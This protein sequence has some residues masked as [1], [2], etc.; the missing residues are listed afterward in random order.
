MKIEEMTTPRPGD[1][2][3]ICGGPPGI[4]GVFQPEEPVKWGAAPGKTRLV[5]YCL[6]LKCHGR[7]ETPEKAEKIIRSELA[8]GGVTHAE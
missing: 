8:G 4:I 6:C 3:L 2:C 1:H 7:P 5:R